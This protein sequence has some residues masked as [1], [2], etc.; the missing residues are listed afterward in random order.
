MLAVNRLACETSIVG[1]VAYVSDVRHDAT[2]ILDDDSCAAVAASCL[3]QPQCGDRVMVAGITDGDAFVL[4]ILERDATRPANLEVPCAQSVTLSSRRLVLAAG[5]CMEMQSMGDIEM[6]S[7][8]GCL[9]IN[10][11]HVTVTAMETLVQSARQYLANLDTCVVQA[12]GLLRLHGQQAI[13]TAEGDMK[14]DA[15]RISVG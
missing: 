11:R 5:E 12:L 1:R 10:A 2:V 9:S 4:A 13:L 14:I 6:T 3:L 8:A 7:A 15:E